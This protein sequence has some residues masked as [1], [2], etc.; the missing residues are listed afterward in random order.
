MK[1]LLRATP[2][3]N[4]ARI[5]TDSTPGFSKGK[6]KGAKLLAAR[7]LELSVLQERIFAE[8]K[9][10]GKRKVLLVIQAMD[11][12]GKGGIVQHVVAAVNPEGVKAKAFKAPTAVEKRHDFLWRIRKELPAAGYLGVFDRSHYEDVLIHRVLGLST[13]AAIEE[14]YGLICDFEAE[15]SATDTTVIKIMLHISLGE[16]KKRLLARLAT[17]DKQWKYSPGDVDQRA[18]WAAYMDAYQVAIRKTTTDAAPWYV[19]P[20]DH[21]W[22]ARLAVQ[23]ILIETLTALDLKWPAPQYDVSV[24]KRRLA[25][26]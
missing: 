13:P 19:I 15:L 2:A 1:E 17:I 12:A 18:H 10:G 8:A 9:G 26:S 4:L 3:L 14:R 5:K 24:E 23:E 16:Q 6:R 21:K 22:Y 25:A 7:A 20:A 11:T